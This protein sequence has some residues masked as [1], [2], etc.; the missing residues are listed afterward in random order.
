M[1][2]LYETFILGEIVIIL[3]FEYVFTCMFCCISL[4]ILYF[5]SYF[6]YYCHS[7]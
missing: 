7:E 1:H 5:M 2:T 3:Y 6:T 4:Y